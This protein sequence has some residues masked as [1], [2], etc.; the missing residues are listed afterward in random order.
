MQFLSTLNFW[1]AD[2]EYLSC[3]HGLFCDLLKKEASVFLTKIHMLSL[4]RMENRFL[5]D[6]ASID[7]MLEILN[8]RIAWYIFNEPVV[9]LEK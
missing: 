1:G 2:L 9:C 5:K 7:F 6:W 4:K 3:N 8:T